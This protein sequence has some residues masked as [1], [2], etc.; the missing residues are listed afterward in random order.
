[1]GLRILKNFRKTYLGLKI[2]E[3]L[4]PTLTNDLGVQ[5]VV[6][7]AMEKFKR[8]SGKKNRARIRREVEVC[9]RF[10]GCYPYQ[11]FLNELYREDCDVTD[12]ELRTYIPPFF[13]YEIFLPY[14]TPRAYR[15]VGEN[16]I[17]MEIF[18]RSLS[19]PRPR[20]LGIILDG[21]LYSA[22]LELLAADQ[23]L[24]T[25]A[26]KIF[27]KP[28]D[29][30]GGKGIRVFHRND[31]GEYVARDGK[32][33]ARYIRERTEKK[34]SAI[35]QEGIVQDP[36]IS[37]IYP[38]SVNTLRI[39]T[40]NKGGKVRLICAAFRMGRG[41]AEVD[42]VSSGGL[43]TSINLNDGR[44]GD[45]ALTENLERFTEHPDTHVPFITY[46]IPRWDD[47]ATFVLHSAG[48]LPFLTY[49]GWDIALTPEGPV[50][51]E[52]N[53]MPDICGIEGLIGGMRDMFHID[54]PMFYWKHLAQRY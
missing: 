27:A 51:I 37:K 9:R 5:A 20:T 41:H 2:R 40:E 21:I 18:F 4:Y 30:Y 33:L 32:E 6:A 39:M 16:K 25:A 14:H 8:S 49:I 19:I 46:F 31:D 12:D 36:E 45:F 38:E 1:M 7:P 53:R 44:I 15:F 54:D 34:E 24:E 3:K 22:E 11:Y 13:W 23:L 43:W 17:V 35:I 52:I 10:W 29:S 42:N 28:V 48:K 47:V 26:E 50:V